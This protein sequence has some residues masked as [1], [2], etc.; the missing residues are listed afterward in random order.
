MNETMKLKIAYYKSMEL[1]MSLQQH[2][3]SNYFMPYLKSYSP[4]AF[5]LICLCCHNQLCLNPTDFLKLKLAQFVH[6]STAPL[7]LCK[8]R[9]SL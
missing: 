9:G 1:F 6:A 2:D 3:G 5:F 8:T 4:I 7:A